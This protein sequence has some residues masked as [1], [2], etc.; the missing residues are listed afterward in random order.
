M[1]T[2]PHHQT[3]RNILDLEYCKNWWG[4]TLFN[5]KDLQQ[6]RPQKVQAALEIH[7]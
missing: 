4:I 6:N 5:I 7:L 3:F 1:E 2:R